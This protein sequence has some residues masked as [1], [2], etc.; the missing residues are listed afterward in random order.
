MID[1]NFKRIYLKR[2][3]LRDEVESGQ[4]P[5]GSNQVALSLIHRMN[6]SVDRTIQSSDDAS[7]C[8]ICSDS[9]VRLVTAQVNTFANIGVG[10]P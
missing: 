5:F 3:W 10:C 7:S 4:E 6:R 2:S 9:F 1:V 8:G